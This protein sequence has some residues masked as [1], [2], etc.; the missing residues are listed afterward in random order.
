M[1]QPGTA[2][3]FATPRFVVRRLHAH[4]L[5]ALQRLFE[6]S[7]D[8]FM[9]VHGRRPR[10]DEAQMEF[11]E[12]PPSTLPHGQR[13]FA[14][15]W[16]AH[17]TLQGVL[18]FVADLMA[19]GVWHIALFFIATPLHGT[20]AARELYGALE[21]WSRQRHHRQQEQ[22]ACSTNQAPSSQEGQRLV[23]RASGGDELRQEGQEEQRH[24]GVE[25]VG[26]QA[27]AE[28]GHRQRGAPAGAA[29]AAPPRPRQACAQHAQASHSR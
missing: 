24:L 17:G 14:G 26:Q 27:G 20:G 9:V 15:A 3:L 28:V 23:R 6:A 12:M 16:D 7:P 2:E 1:S 5:A 8:Y 11:A 19:P 4:D 13:W 25:H 10:T 18:H 29:P 22:R 21:A